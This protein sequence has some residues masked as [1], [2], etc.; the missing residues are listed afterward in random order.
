MTQRPV[1]FDSL[2]TARL[3]LMTLHRTDL[4]SEERTSNF[5][6]ESD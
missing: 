1:D 6:F 3:S 5:N 4:G 2:P